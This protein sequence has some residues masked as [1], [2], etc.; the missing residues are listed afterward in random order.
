MLP[1]GI[2]IA[3]LAVH[4]GTI[5]A[6]TAAYRPV[7]GGPYATGH[8]VYRSIDA[9]ASWSLATQLRDRPVDVVA[10]TT[11]FIATTTTG[12]FTS[13]DGMT[14]APLATDRPPLA[15][16]IGG[17]VD[18]AGGLV[19]ATDDGLEVR[20]AGGWT[21]APGT[22][23]HER[24]GGVAAHGSMVL[25][26]AWTGGAYR[27]TGGA[28]SRVGPSPA[29][30]VEVVADMHHVHVWLARD[31]R[32]VWRSTDDGRSWQRL[33]GGPDAYA[34]LRSMTVDPGSGDV[35][36]VASGSF[37]SSKGAIYRWHPGAGW[38]R[39]VAL[40]VAQYDDLSVL[41]VRDRGLRLY[42]S[43]YACVHR[44]TDGGRT[45]SRCRAYRTSR[46][47]LAV[48]PADPRTI[49]ASTADFVEVSH[50]SGATFTKLPPSIAGGAIVA[51]GPL[52]LHVVDGERGVFDYLP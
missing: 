7:I 29:G 51:V 45:W 40:T 11:G 33:P 13:V 8:G 10:T 21:T 38:R 31:G 48:D 9:G 5:A 27:S 24:F 41:A 16:T 44:S 3:S 2:E 17:L 12:T 34:S 47:G 4:T 49:Y 23:P 28:F 36:A 32:H 15:I 37:G 19:A 43:G 6:G 14:Y 1:A 25:A 35:I 26:T 30:I 20:G 52:G 42:L 18:A 50:D 46:L 39:V 22:P